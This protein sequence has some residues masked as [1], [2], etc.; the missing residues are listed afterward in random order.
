MLSRTDR[1]DA[2]SLA[3]AIS[4][5]QLEFVEGVGGKDIPE[6]AFPPGGSKDSVKQYAY[7]GAFYFPISEI[8]ETS[9]ASRE[10]CI[11]RMRY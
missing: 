4:K 6:A 11:A 3:A 9:L 8:F 2:T 10:F 5:L 7:S 1:R